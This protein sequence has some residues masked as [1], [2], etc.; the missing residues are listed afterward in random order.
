M[1]NAPALPALLSLASLPV[2]ALVTGCSTPAPLTHVDRPMMPD[3]AVAVAAGK[4]P[5]TVVTTT[6]LCARGSLLLPAGTTLE[7]SYP[8]P[9]PYSPWRPVYRLRL[10]G[11]SSWWPA[12][13]VLSKSG[14]AYFSYF[15]VPTGPL[16][17]FRRACARNP[18]PCC[19]VQAPAS[20]P[21]K[22]PVKPHR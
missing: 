15:V 22:N 12:T 21:G 5:N 16:E 9:Y 8:T 2:L 11:K 1:K 13:A 3:R 19:P 14:V 7:F 20:N 18:A 6:P 4:L 10:P 17:A